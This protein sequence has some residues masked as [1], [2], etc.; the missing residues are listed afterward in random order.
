M[1]AVAEEM[2]GMEGAREEFEDETETEADEAVVEG[3]RSGG[4][5]TGL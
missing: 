3:N 2:M 1:A 5:E 4:G